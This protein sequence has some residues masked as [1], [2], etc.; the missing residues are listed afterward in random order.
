MISAYETDVAGVIKQEFITY[1]VV[2]NMLR[3]RTVTRRFNADQTDWYDTVS[4][5]PLMECK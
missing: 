1:L 3:V 2:N 5:D 4:V